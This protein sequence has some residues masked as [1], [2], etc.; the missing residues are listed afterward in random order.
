LWT[1]DLNRHWSAGLI[2]IHQRQPD[3]LQL[4]NFKNLSRVNFMRNF[5]VAFFCTG[6][7]AALGSTAAHADQGYGY[8]NDALTSFSLTSAGGGVFDFSFSGSSDSGSGAF[9]TTTT[10]TAGQY[11]ITGISGTLDSSAITAL[12][13]AGTFPTTFGGGDNLLFDPGVIGY[14]DS[15]PS[16]LDIS[17]VSFQVTGGE[18][19]NL[20]YGVF[21]GSD[22]EAYDLLSTT[23]D[24]PSPNDPAPTPEPES[25][26]LLGTGM[27][28]LVGSVRRRFLAA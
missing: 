25:L 16:F 17:G 9:T 10:G 8:T 26:V 2:A 27:L 1:L 4:L 19:F 14:G 15:N 13:P 22:P 7:I 23:P 12:D 20:Y 21:Q 6:L 18:D 5:V 11:L 24:V 28:G 3:E